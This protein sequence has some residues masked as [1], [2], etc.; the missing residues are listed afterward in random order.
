MQSG[1]QGFSLF[2]CP[3]T[4]EPKLLNIFQATAS[5]ITL[6]AIGIDQRPIKGCIV[7]EIKVQ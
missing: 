1:L 2:S 7:D 5:S 6:T 4:H 3:E